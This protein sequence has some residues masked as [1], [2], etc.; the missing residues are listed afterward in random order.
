MNR[1][2]RSDRRKLEAELRSLPTPP[3]PPELLD[4]LKADIPA[5]LGAANDG[6]EAEVAAAPVRTFT[7][8]RRWPLRLAASLALAVLGGLVAWQVTERSA[9]APSRA[10]GAQSQAATEATA[11]QP[12]ERTLAFAPPAEPKPSEPAAPETSDALKKLPVKGVPP[13]S[14]QQ[15]QSANEVAEAASGRSHDRKALAAGAPPAPVP[16]MEAVSPQA[17]TALADSQDIPIDDA[18]VGIPETP[19]EIAAATPQRQQ[20]GEKRAR[21]EV[22]AGAE[23]YATRQVQMPPPPGERR[24]PAAPAAA[25]AP[26]TGGSAEPNEQAYGD[27]F[28][29]PAGTNPF[30]DSEEDALSTFA[31]D[32]D[33]GS[34]TLA[35]EYLRRGHLPPAEGIRVEEFVNAFDYRDPAPRRGDF[36]LVAEGAPSPFSPGERYRLLRFAAKAREIDAGDRKPAVLTFVVDVSGSMDRE[37][38]LGLVKRA[39]GLL[40]DQLD[41][42][43]RVA[44]VVY[45]SQGRVLLRHT[46]DLGEIR[47]AIGRLVPEGSTNAEEGLRLAYEVA[48]EGYRAG[49]VNRVILCSDGVAN[50][51]ATGPESILERIGREARRGIELTTVGFGMGNYNDALMERLA[52]QGDGRYAYVDTLDEARRI[53]V[54]ELTGTLETVAGD[55]KAQ[56]EFEPRTVERW[57][58]LGYENRDVA[59]RDFRN[60]RID[61]GELGAGHAATA[62]YEIRLAPDARG[63]DRVATLRLRWKSKATGRVEEI[64]RPLFVRDLARDWEDAPSSL[65]LAGVAAELAEILRGSYWA[66]DAS[67]ADVAGEARQVARERRGDERASELADLAATASRLAG[68]RGGTADP[69]D[70]R[71]DERDRDRE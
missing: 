60:D 42:G 19:A 55:A 12:I 6:D 4:R 36:A 51:G 16:S 71:E 47:S 40:L 31:L 69:D 61:A 22:N 15:V 49:S 32:V 11:P 30:V 7:P 46:R 70:R 17:A 35:R 28:F 64:E 29:R 62:L 39:L 38:R 33:T 2:N 24:L 26:S 53:F 43:D 44:L 41:A 37:N 54:E 50:V 20:T 27:M 23:G 1:L 52:D 68:R 13:G 21:L 63:G 45:G 10:A 59:D 48:D 56:V 58:L 3:P 5:H 14:P 34:Y 9:P 25:A 8:A 67:L 57:R 65:R 18:V 66:K